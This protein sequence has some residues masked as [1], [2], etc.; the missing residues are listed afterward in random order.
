MTELC[1]EPAKCNNDEQTFKA[2]LSRWMAMTT[3]LAPFTTDSIMPVLRSSAIA[4]MKQCDGTFFPNNCGLRWSQNATWDGSNGPGQQMAALEIL[5]STII[6]GVNPPL[7]SST[8]GTS[9][10]DPTAGL[11]KSDSSVDPGT[12]IQPA[13][14]SEKVVAWFVTGFIILST[15]AGSHFLWSASFE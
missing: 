4:A 9:A 6:K 13:T 1:E 3:Q 14:H 12:I 15:I 8:G 2:Y 11:N 7:T 10:S 5:L